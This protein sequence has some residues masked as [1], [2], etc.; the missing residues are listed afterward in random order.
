[1]PNIEPT[2]WT[3]RTTKCH[4]QFIKPYNVCLCVRERGQPSAIYFSPKPISPVAVEGDKEITIDSCHPRASHFSVE[5][6]KLPGSISFV[7]ATFL[8]FHTN[9]TGNINLRYVIYQLKPPQQMPLGMI[10]EGIG[11]QLLSPVSVLQ[12]YKGR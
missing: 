5:R 4:R 11:Q 3:G 9:S 12:S 6:Y 7:H 8:C 1:L 2:L 10:S